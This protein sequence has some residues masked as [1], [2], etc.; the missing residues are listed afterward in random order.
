MTLR[1]A[2]QH[3]PE[4]VFIIRLSEHGLVTA[5]KH[6]H[7]PAQVQA[8]KANHEPDSTSLWPGLSLGSWCS[9]LN[10][11]G[12]CL[13]NFGYER[14]HIKLKLRLVVSLQS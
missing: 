9:F 14:N 10:A 12:G 8:L 5:S 1:L 11:C 2:H 13:F 7:V 6:I 3:Q 4:L